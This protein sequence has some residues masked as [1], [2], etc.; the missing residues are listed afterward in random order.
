MNFILFGMSLVDIGPKF[1][2]VIPTLGP[3]L[4]VKVTDFKFACKNQILCI[5]YSYKQEFS[6]NTSG[7][8]VD[9]GLELDSG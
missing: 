6:M 3:D 9:I 2:S 7:M 8:I 4:E 5:L 1:Y